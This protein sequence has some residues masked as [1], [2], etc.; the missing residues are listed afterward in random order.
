MEN[1]YQVH[2]L[3]DDMDSVN[4]DESGILWENFNAQAF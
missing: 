3:D 4:G 1:S 2:L